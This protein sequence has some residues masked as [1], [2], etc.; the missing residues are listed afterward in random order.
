MNKTEIENNFQRVQLKIITINNE[1]HEWKTANQ[2]DDLNKFL[3]DIHAEDI[4]SINTIE[5][6][7]DYSS[8]YKIF[9]YYKTINLEYTLCSFCGGYL[10]RE[11]EGE[12][13]WKHHFR[14]SEC[15]ELFND[16]L[17]HINQKIKKELEKGD[18][19]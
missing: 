10:K 19:K 4:V 13:R 17:K 14:C 5:E 16:K 11:E 8:Q 2:I 15:G 6:K 18:E 12:R 9:I 7:F 3:G 1:R